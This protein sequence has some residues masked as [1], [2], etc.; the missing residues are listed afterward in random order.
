MYRDS[1]GK[2]EFCA[3]VLSSTAIGAIQCTKLKT[4]LCPEN[5]Y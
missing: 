5:A 2:R 3:R 4:G 1:E